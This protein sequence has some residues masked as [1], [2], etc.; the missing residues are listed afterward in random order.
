MIDHVL[1]RRLVIVP[2]AAIVCV[3]LGAFASCSRA[4]EPPPHRAFQS[5]EDAVKALNDAVAKENIAEV[6][7]I[8]GPDSRELIDSSDPEIARKNRQV[9]TVAMAEGWRLVDENDGKTL[10]IGNEQWPFPVPLVNDTRGW[11]F[12]T[13]AG[14]EEVLARRIGRNELKAIQI[15]E[16]YTAAQRVYAQDGH[17]GKPAGLYARVFRSDAGKQNGL[18]WPT[19]RGQ[20]RS[21]LGELMPDT[22][23]ER[24]KTAISKPQPF[25]GYYFKILTGQGAAAPG[26]AKEYVVNGEMSG[27][28]ALV[29]W[30]AEYDLTGIMTFVVNHDG[31]VHQ[32]DLG[33]E[34]DTAARS[35]TH[36]DPDATWTPVEGPLD[37]QNR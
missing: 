19:G 6:T 4:E 15:C 21:P 12:D 31:V 29:A 37:A 2:A 18:Y 3:A 36:Y 34:T 24:A 10:V 7:A 1:T 9:F 13:A 23:D 25:H 35:M 28:F 33:P 30:P 14:K 20:K 32:K 27:G 26:G 16:T 17:D 5:P 8:F 22:A 11:R